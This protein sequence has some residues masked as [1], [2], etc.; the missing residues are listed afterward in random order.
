[1]LCCLRILQ[2]IFQGIPSACLFLAHLKS[3]KKKN[4]NKKQGSGNLA[5][6]PVVKTLLSTSGGAGL[7]S[8]LG[9]KIP[10]ALG[11]ENRNIEQK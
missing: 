1:M 2:K 9:A 11:T 8:S 4:K 7:V 3:V 6:G 5:G 10:H